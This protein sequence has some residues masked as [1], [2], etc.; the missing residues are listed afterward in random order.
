MG[1]STSQGQGG[2]STTT[3]GGS[4]TTPPNGGT[5]TATGGGG[6][7][8]PASGG[9]G[10]AAPAC[11]PDLTNLVNPNGWICALDTEIKMQGAWYG[12]G[13]GTSCTPPSN[14]CST[15][16]CC[17]KGATVTPDANFTQ[18]G[19]GMGLELNSTGGTTPVKT[20]YGGP[21]KCFDIAL[22]GSSG[23]N[24][25]RIGFTQASDTTGKVSPYKEIPPFTDGWKGQVCFTDTECPDWAVTAKSCDKTVG[26]AG[27]PYDMQIQVSAGETTA[28]DFNVCVASIA[29]VTSSGMTGT[30]MSCS[31]ATGSGSIS[32]R[33]G[34]QH[35]TC[36]G[37]DYIVQNNAWGSTA[38]Q[39]ITY[40][41][42]TKMKVT[43]QNGTG[44]SGA[45]A[46]YPSIFLGANAGH[47]TADSGLPK[48]VSAIAKGGVLTSWTWASNGATGSYNAAYDVWFGTSAGGEA[49]ASA[50]S[51]GYLMV[52]YH[53]P[54]SD[55]PIGTSVATATLAGKNW[56]VWYGTNSGSGKPCVSYVAQQDISSLSFS[57]GDFIRDAVDRKYLQDSWYLT[58]VFAGFEIW[59]GG[60]G[61]ETKDFSVSP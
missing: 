25:V 32:D 37:K 35:V 33:F 11:V 7:A 52:W 5:S 29:P 10:G 57:L 12:Y 24:V 20:V 54:S 21:V 26:A 22:T 19:C 44:A 40:G 56:S 60:V 50:P 27:T 6:G 13:D 39:T 53:Q 43:S 36:N 3:T 16:S 42:G 46:S 49:A 18:W 28:S 55:Q 48:A 4:T 14:I 17:M 34:T 2:S 30:T 45:P 51:G 41:T 47:T 8:P 23:K 1:G 58:N 61:L 15:G 9:S 59:S 31:S 38:G